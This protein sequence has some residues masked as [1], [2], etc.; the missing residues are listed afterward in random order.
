MAASFAEIAHDHG[1]PMATHERP[2]MAAT[3]PACR[4]VVAAREHVGERAARLLMRRLRIRH[5]SG[6]LLDEP[7]TIAGA[8][9]D[10]GLDP[11]T[12]RSWSADPH[13]EAALSVDMAA[14]RQ[15]IPAA[16]V[17]DGKL[18]NWSGGRRYTC[19]SYEIVRA[20]D[21]VK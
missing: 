8:A 11:E 4:A 17:L 7:E 15:P 3:M 14:A 13:V 18:A 5:F 6:E 9:R 12:L 21:G 19:P 2:R 10:V 16:C 1:M 20:V